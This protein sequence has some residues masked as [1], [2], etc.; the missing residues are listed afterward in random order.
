MSNH[1]QVG[2]HG[3]LT[4]AGLSSPRKTGSVSVWAHNKIAFHVWGELLGTVTLILKKKRFLKADTEV[5]IFEYHLTL[6]VGRLHK[7]KPSI[8]DDKI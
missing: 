1:S 4:R 6:A 2:E 7:H 8:L 3:L 5:F